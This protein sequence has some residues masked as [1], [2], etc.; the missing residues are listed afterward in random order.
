[1]PPVE[2]R[3]SYGRIVL[4]IA[5][6]L[7]ILFIF[8]QSLL[9]KSLSS[10]ESGWLMNT[11][12]NPL[13]QSIGLKPLSHHTIRKIAH[14]AEFTVLSMLLVLTFRGRIIRSAGVGFTIAFLDESIQLLSGR[15]ASVTDIW[16]DLIGVAIGTALGFLL[17]NTRKHHRDKTE[18]TQ[19]V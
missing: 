7:M 15:G 11:V 8:A 6:A 16:I 3:L 14:V 2:K 1:M 18:Q 12:I 13:L 4:L 17:Q 5:T 9:P 10:E 19:S